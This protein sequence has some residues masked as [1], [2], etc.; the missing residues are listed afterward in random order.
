M[1]LLR[2]SKQ[3]I[4]HA[5]ELHRL[6]FVFRMNQLPA[7]SRVPVALAVCRTTMAASFHPAA[8]ELDSVR[9]GCPASGRVLETASSV[10]DG[11]LLPPA[12]DRTGIRVLA[13]RCARR[14][15]ERFRVM[16]RCRSANDGIRGER[17]KGEVSITVDVAPLVCR[18]MLRK[19][20][21]HST[22]GS[23]VPVYVAVRSDGERAQRHGHTA[24][25][26]R[27]GDDPS[28]F[29]RD[30]QGRASSRTV[31]GSATGRW[32]VVAGV[33]GWNS[34]RRRRTDIV[35]LRRFEER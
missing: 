18:P 24:A 3:I 20:V 35:G 25:G 22:T 16:V 30:V 17:R 23:G 26:D 27:R 32:T 29:T 11:R 15:G 33:L 34:T 4:L 9:C 5:Y 21:N 28:G 2:E 10:V 31:D 13:G 8:P 12:S 14:D 19:C 1:I 6:G 7:S